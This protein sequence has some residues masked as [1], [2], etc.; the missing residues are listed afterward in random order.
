VKKRVGGWA[1]IA[2]L[3]TFV[4]GPSLA[5]EDTA[6]LKDLT[7]VIALQG[8]PCRRVVSAVRQGD[9]DYMASRQDGHRYRVFIDGQGRVVV[10][11]R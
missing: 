2:L 10:E 8:E 5:E 6:V 1:V 11:K 4:A 7:A 3:T 9:N